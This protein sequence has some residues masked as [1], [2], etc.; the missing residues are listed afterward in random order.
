MLRWS[1]LYALATSRA[2]A[3][4]GATLLLVPLIV[5]GIDYAATSFELTHL[6]GLRFTLVLSFSAAVFGMIAFA[7]ANVFCPHEIKQHGTVT[8]FLEQRLRLNHL[9]AG[10]AE[11][12]L[13]SSVAVFH[14]FLESYGIKIG[15]EKRDWVRDQLRLIA[16]SNMEPVARS[17][18]LTDI[19]NNMEK[20]NQTARIAVALALTLAFG[21]TLYFFGRNA[22]A[23]FF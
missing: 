15:T 18:Q 6:D 7:V 19:W 10:D 8:Q 5:R 23:V 13:E 17:T 22:A 16:L 11:R 2:L 9:Q 21:T 12:A 4:G 20:A 3:A 14:R 1:V